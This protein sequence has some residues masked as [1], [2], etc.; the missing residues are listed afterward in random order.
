[1]RPFNIPHLEE[2]VAVYP[3]HSRDRQAGSG[4]SHRTQGC[5]SGPYQPGTQLYRQAGS[6]ASHRTQGCW[7]GTYQPGTQLYRQAGS[8]ASHRTQGCWSVLY[9][10]AFQISILNTDHHTEH[11]WMWIQYRSR[12][13]STTNSLQIQIHKESNTDR[14]RIRIHKATEYGSRSIMQSNTDPDP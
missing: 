12:R 3:A 4:A 11:Y 7:S 10:T 9:L 8:G 5:W 6:G 1:M 14:T 13:T 2:P